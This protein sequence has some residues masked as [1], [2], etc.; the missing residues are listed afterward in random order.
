VSADITGF[1]PNGHWETVS[2]SSPIGGPCSA[3][4]PHKPETGKSSR[5]AGF[6]DGETRTRT[7]DTTIF[8]R[9]VVSLERHRNRCKSAAS[10][11]A[12]GT[13]ERP[14]IPVFPFRFGRWVAPRLP[15]SVGKSVSA[16]PDGPAALLRSSGLGAPLVGDG[17]QPDR[18]TV[19]GDEHDGLAGRAELRDW[20]VC[21]VTVLVLGSSRMQRRAVQTTLD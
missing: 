8:S 21:V 1:R 16:T 20:T 17:E 2:F 3:V 13:T 9:A 12:E 19:A 5:D 4:T 18:L 6:S 10:R 14:Q 15:I 11:Q 7:G